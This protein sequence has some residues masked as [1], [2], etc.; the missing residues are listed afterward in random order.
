MSKSTGQN[1]NFGK[2]FSV[3]GHCHYMLPQMNCTELIVKLTVSPFSSL[4]AQLSFFFQALMTWKV[5]KSSFA[6][7][8][9]QRAFISVYFGLY[10]L[11]MLHIWDSMSSFSSLK[12][13]YAMFSAFSF[14]LV[15]NRETLQCKSLSVCL[16]C[17]IYKSSVWIQIKICFISEVCMYIYRSRPVS[18]VKTSKI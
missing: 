6:L 5:H 4:Q 13:Q 2:C 10:F 18:S 17:C 3:F 16:I 1:L 14:Q 15:L 8:F 7:K 9:L 11:K 12:E